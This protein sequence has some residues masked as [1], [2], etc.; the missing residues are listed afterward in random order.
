MAHQRN[1]VL[2]SVELVPRYEL[3]LDITKFVDRNTVHARSF[4]NGIQV[5]RKRIEQFFRGGLQGVCF[6]TNA[7]GLEILFISSAYH[8]ERE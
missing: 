2:E 7:G 1:L 4:G 5:V 6:I 8:D 3:V